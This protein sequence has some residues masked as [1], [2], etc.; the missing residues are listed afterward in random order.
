MS[1]NRAY[2]PEKEKWLQERYAEIHPGS[3]QDEKFMILG[4][5]W[6]VL[7][8][9]TETRQSTVKIMAACR[10]SDAGSVYL[11]QQARCLA[12]PCK[13]RYF[14]PYIFCIHYGDLVFLEHF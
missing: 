6:R 9:N 1:Q 8:F 3:Q 14:F 5:Q 13:F 2:W 11:M 4:Y 12:V 10:E 7:R